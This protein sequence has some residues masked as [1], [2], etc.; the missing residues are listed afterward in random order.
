[1]TD[2]WLGEFLNKMT[3]LGFME[4]TLLMVLSDHGVMLGEHNITGKPPWA[5]WPELTDIVF[6]M[7]HPEGKGAGKTS[8]YFASIHDIAPTILGMTDIQR[9]EVMNGEDLSVLFD[10]KEPGARPHFTL[11]YNNHSWAR[12]DRHALIVR[13]DRAEAKLFDIQADPGMNRDISGK[14]PNVVK[15]MFENYVLGD[16]GGSPPMY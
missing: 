1:M 8:D 3:D 16:A 15:R 6:Y 11:G 9:P 2:H 7:R 12:D 14:N 13:N 10:G 5:I 4:N